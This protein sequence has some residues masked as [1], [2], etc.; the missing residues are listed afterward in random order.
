MT[1][2]IKDKTGKFAGSLP[3]EPKIASS[4]QL[5]QV[6]NLPT[7]PAVEVKPVFGTPEWHAMVAQKRLERE[8][9][10]QSRAAAR[11][12]IYNFT[13]KINSEFPN[14]RYF[15]FDQDWNPVAIE[16]YDNEVLIDLKSEEHGA[17]ADTL[18]IETANCIEG[19]KTFVETGYK[20]PDG[21]IGVNM[22]ILCDE[23][24]GCQFRRPSKG[25]APSHEASPAC[26]S[27]K[28]PHCTCDTCF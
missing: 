1:K 27:G 15:V 3:D 12:V 14:S 9:Q 13:D 16:A 11:E 26:Q 4:N 5:S 10:E 18:K 2:Y 19:L 23:G 25:W 21:N 24:D 17:L 22:L 8:A 7:P 6:P 28:R 20:S